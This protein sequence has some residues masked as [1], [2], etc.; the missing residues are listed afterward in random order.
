MDAAQG[1]P[2]R[3]VGVDLVKLL[4]CAGV[5]FIYL[6]GR[7]SSAVNGSL[8]FLAGFAVPVFFM[9]NGCFVLNKRWLGYAYVLGK[10]RSVLAVVVLWVALWWAAMCVKNRV[11][12][13]PFAL[14]ANSL[15]GT[16][17]LSWFWFFGVL[18]LVQLLSPLMAR[19]NAA[20]P[21]AQTTLLVVS[22]L[23]CLCVH[24]CDLEAATSAPRAS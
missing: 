4:A 12:I 13:D 14:L 21:R 24:A 17:G 7:D 22:V 16:G 6:I 11:L 1:R 19:V 9:A 8:F 2:A 15:L 18:V 5:L 3:N 23:S 20:S 10:V